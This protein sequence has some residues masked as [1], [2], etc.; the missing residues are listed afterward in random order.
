M[1]Q[2]FWR[3]YEVAVNSVAVV[4]FTAMVVITAL[5]VFFRYVLNAPLHWTEEADR[6]VFIWL[7]FIGASITMRYKAHIAVDV[8]VRYLPTRVR[9]WTTLAAQVAALV[10]LAIVGWASLP[11]IEVTMESRAT[12]TDIPMGLVYLSVPVGCTLIAVETLR[13]IA[14]TLGEARRGTP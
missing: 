9:V 13:L 12:A 6:Y 2:T 14:R 3:V 1:T 7:T 5:G 4:L 8:L 10:F 11:V